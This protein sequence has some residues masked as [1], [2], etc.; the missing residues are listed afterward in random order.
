MQGK[1]TAQDI[2][3]LAEASQA[4]ALRTLHL[5]PSVDPLLN[6]CVIDVAQGHSFF[7]NMIELLRAVFLAWLACTSAFRPTWHCSSG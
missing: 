1:L 5:N 6:L 2:P 7:P 3:H 4:A